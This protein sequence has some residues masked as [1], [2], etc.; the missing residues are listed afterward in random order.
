[1]AKRYGVPAATVVAGEVVEAT[2]KAMTAKI[3]DLIRQKEAG[4]ITKDEVEFD[5]VAPSEGPHP[6]WDESTWIEVVWIKVTEKFS[7]K[8]R[9]AK[10]GY[11]AFAK[12]VRVVF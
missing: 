6:S 3:E 12:R 11:L 4:E 7:D 9:V 5:L 8:S 1:M 2:I 10:L